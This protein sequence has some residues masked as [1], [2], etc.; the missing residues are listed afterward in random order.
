MNNWIKHDS[1]NLPTTKE[2]TSDGGETAGTR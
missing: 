2:V 1:N